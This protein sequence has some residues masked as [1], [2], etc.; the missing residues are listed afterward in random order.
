MKAIK[1]IVGKAW[2]LYVFA[3]ATI[4]ASWYMTYHTIRIFGT[5][6]SRFDSWDSWFWTILV[7]VLSLI[8]LIYSIFDYREKHK[9]DK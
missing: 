4:G 5:T 8:Y 1:E 6:I 3:L 7:G 2:I 9:N